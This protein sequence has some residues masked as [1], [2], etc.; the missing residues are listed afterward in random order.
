MKSILGKLGFFAL[1]AAVLFAGQIADA[2]T[3][4]AVSSFKN[5]SGSSR[6]SIRWFSYNNLGSGMA[7]QLIT[8]LSDTNK[9]DIQERE[10]LQKMYNQE[11]Q[12][13]NADKSSLPEANKFRSAHYSIVGSITSFEMCESG[14]KAKLN[15]GK[16]IGLKSDRLKV[17]AK[18]S[19]A[20]VVLDLRVIDV[21]KGN[22]LKSVR[23]EG[24]VSS[25]DFDVD[26][27]VKG[28]GFDTGAFQRSPV[29]EATRKA[30]QNAVDQIVSVVP[31]RKDAPV[32]INDSGKAVRKAAAKTASKAPAQKVAKA[33]RT[34]TKAKQFC[35]KD[36]KYNV[37]TMCKPLSQSKK[38]GYQVLY[39][40]N[41]KKS[42]V[43]ASNVKVL[44]RHSKANVG[45]DVF[46]QCKSLGKYACGTRIN[47]KK[48]VAQCTVMDIAG[49]QAAINCWSK[50]Y[51][52]KA[53]GLYQLKP[54]KGRKT[55]SR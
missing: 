11:H 5:K 27:S 42:I 25:T 45:D 28:A 4:V 53:R 35:L 30:I 15:V 48:S 26:G 46:V 37:Y 8:A 22:V 51:N 43:P 31:D 23:A 21:T 44:K 54:Y 17:G 1:C 3:R 20:K 12:L 13:I 32:A 40:D 6:C 19:N 52:I 36:E 9:F 49:D 10:N 29:G 33:S 34:S 18:K 41:A 55:A 24:S 50:D 47:D 16:L 2:K 14:G 38:G 7:D 39:M